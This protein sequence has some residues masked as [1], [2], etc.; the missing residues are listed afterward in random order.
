MLPIALFRSGSHFPATS[1]A[2]AANAANAA[3]VA[4]TAT[5]PS[6]AIGADAASKVIKSREH[7]DFYSFSM[8]MPILFFFIRGN[9]RVMTFLCPTSLSLLPLNALTNHFAL[10]ASTQMRV[11]QTLAIP[12]KVLGSN[13]GPETK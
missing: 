3:T 9:L 2:R 13:L 4:T 11:S 5:A 1:A 10:F 12:F 8:F 7:S 6:A